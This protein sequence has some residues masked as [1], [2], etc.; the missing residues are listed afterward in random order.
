ML[1]VKAPGVIVPGPDGVGNSGFWGESTAGL[2][3]GCVHGD[4]IFEAEGFSFKHIPL[5]PPLG[6]GD[7]RG[8]IFIPPLF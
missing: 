3:S 8:R 1:N 4:D 2:T 7:L 5:D 6:K